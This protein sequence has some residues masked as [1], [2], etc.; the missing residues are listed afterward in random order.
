M[1][2]QLTFSLRITEVLLIFDM[3]IFLSVEIAV[4]PM[5]GPSQLS[6]EWEQQ[7]EIEGYIPIET[8]H[9]KMAIGSGTWELP[10]CA[11]CLLGYSCKTHKHN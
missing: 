11:R 6:L 8:F 4:I 9:K 5:V 7:E 2:P 1:I 3:K 10:G